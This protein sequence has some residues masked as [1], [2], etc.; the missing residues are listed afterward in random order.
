MFKKLSFK[1]PH[2]Y[3]LISLLIILAAIGTYTIPAGELTRHKDEKTGKT[4]VVPNTFH[5]V[6]AHHVNLFDTVM[7]LPKG[8]NEASDIVFFV[9]LVGGV[10]QIITSTGTINRGISHA[11]V[12]LK[13]KENLLVPCVMLVLATG[14]ATFG[15]AEESLIFIPLAVALAK[16]V[17][18]DAIVGL[19]M[20]YLGAYV[21]YTAGP[22]NPFNTGIAQGIAELPL[23]SG[24]GFRCAT[25]AL[26]Y[27]LVLC[28]IMRYAIKIRK[29]PTKSFMYGVKADDIE[30]NFN[31]G[32]TL[33]GRDKLTLL[34]IV[35]GFCF[36][37]YG[38][39]KKGYYLQ[40]IIT[41]FLFMGIISGLIGKLSFE[42]I[43]DNFVEGVKSMA[44][45]AI[46][47]GLA[48]AIVVVLTEG[49]IM[50][51]VIFGLSKAVGWLP[52]SMGAVGM[53][54]VQT[55]LNFIFASGSGQAAT[56]MPIM[57]PLGDTLGITRQVSVLAFQFGDGITNAISPIQ[58]VLMAAIGLAGIPY[59]KW[60]KYVW[61]LMLMWT[62][63]AAA[64]LIYAT[65]THLGPF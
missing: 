65:L 8:L 43:A 44:F 63:L 27:I 45:T 20:I 13:G 26:F 19:S 30:I 3:I 34:V 1:V 64:I 61:P 28:W 56:T 17:G 59:T 35:F 18:F 37:A 25:M 62:L 16:G 10:F 54:A 52:A 38:V 47:I 7:A 46:C 9:L 41:I 42:Q 5:K 31:D 55:V 29:D 22:L 60:V 53:L 4:L 48:R 36:L 57:A 39:I 2:T 21:G 50:D 24:I 14:G 40:E 33:S 58:P 6:D 49:N 23:F 15:M 32:A 51:S 12:K 11:V